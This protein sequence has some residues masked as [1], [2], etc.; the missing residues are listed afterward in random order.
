MFLFLSYFNLLISFLITL[1]KLVPKLILP[2]QNTSKESKPFFFSWNILQYFI[3]IYYLFLIR[4]PSICPVPQK[5]KPT[6]HSHSLHAVQKVFKN[7]ISSI[8]SLHFSLSTDSWTCK[9]KTH[10][11]SSIPLFIPIQ[12]RGA[13]FL[14]IRFRFRF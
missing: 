11:L 3:Y 9:E 2:F 14:L 7:P 4:S 1:I 8:L 6:D 13:E 5:L 12:Y 10:L